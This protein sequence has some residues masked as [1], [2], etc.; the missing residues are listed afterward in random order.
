MMVSGSPSA[1][2]DIANRSK[3]VM[4]PQEQQAAY[5]AWLQSQL[6][7][8]NQ[9]QGYSDAYNAEQRAYQDLSKALAK[10]GLAPSDYISQNMTGNGFAQGPNIPDSLDGQALNRYNL[11]WASDQSA[12]IRQALRDGTP[13][14]TIANASPEVTKAIQAYQAAYGALPQVD[15]MGNFGSSIQPQLS[16]HTMGLNDYEN[17]QKMLGDARTLGTQGVNSWNQNIQ[18]VYNNQNRNGQAYL[19]MIG[20][21]F[22]GGINPW[23]TNPQWSGSSTPQ[24]QAPQFANDAQLRLQ[25]MQSPWGQ[26]G[27]PFQ[28]QAWAGGI[29]GQSPF[30]PN[31]TNPFQP[32]PTTGLGM[33]QEKFME[34]QNAQN[35]QTPQWFSGAFNPNSYNPQLAT[36]APW[37]GP[38]QNNAANGG[39]AP[40]F[41]T[42]TQQT[43][44][45]G[46]SSPSWGATPQPPAG[47]SG[48]TP[49]PPMQPDYYTPP[50]AQQG[51]PMAFGQS[52][53]GTWK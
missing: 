40:W 17:L 50:G 2:A 26:A 47:Y 22:M 42:P 5:D 15:A 46:G 4:S 33:A 13:I 53:W 24:W 14:P 35:T 12:A 36:N 51:N 38:F 27:A 3:V 32:S 7:Q 41:A 48:G 19:D 43:P 21:G 34:Q 49:P 10:S 39:S 9:L 1:N 16:Q 25:A 44:S 30:T 45:Y 8:T 37:G 11:Y 23:A 29:L 31:M 6:A 18:D 20:G 52:P 28:Q